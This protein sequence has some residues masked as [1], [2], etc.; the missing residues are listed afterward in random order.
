MLEI[1][2]LCIVWPS[3]LWP[4]MDEC[5][6]SCGTHWSAGWERD[7]CDG[8][9]VNMWPRASIKKVFVISVPLLHLE[10]LSFFYC[11]ITEQLCCVH[12]S[13]SS[14]NLSAIFVVELHPKTAL[15]LL[16]VLLLNV[17][18][19]CYIRA[20]IGF[21][22]GLLLFHAEASRS[23]KLLRYLTSLSISLWVFQPSMPPLLFYSL[24]SLTCS[25]SFSFSMSPLFHFLPVSSVW[26][27]SLKFYPFALLEVW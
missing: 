1:V 9:K 18:V 26:E 4:Q 13:P 21:N 12:S 17:P 14:F 25:F 20:Q 19:L 6:T 24:L 16:S 2:M 8:Y 7:T 27:C 22:W 11:S 5:R 15:A 23:Y 10:T 3:W